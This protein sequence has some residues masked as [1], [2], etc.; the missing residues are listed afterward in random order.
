MRSGD[1]GV[2]GQHLAVGNTLLGL[3]ALGLAVSGV[4]AAW[5][6][7]LRHLDPLPMAVT[8]IAMAVLGAWQ[9]ASVPSQET[10]G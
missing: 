9:R 5:P 6:G 1:E 4:S 8:C 2:R 7:G 10:S 3:A